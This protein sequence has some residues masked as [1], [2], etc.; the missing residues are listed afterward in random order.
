MKTFSNKSF[1]VLLL[2]T[3]LF[4]T[5]TGCIK[6]DDN[7]NNN[8]TETSTVT[9][10]DG[11]VYQTVKIGFQWWMA[12]NL[13]TTKYNDGSNIIYP[14]QDT[15]AWYNNTTGAYAWYN[16]DTSNKDKYGA[17]YN[18]FAVNTG[19]LCP[20]G[21]SVPTHSN[22]FNLTM[23]ADTIGEGTVAGKLKS[24]RQENSPQ[25]GDC[26]TNEHP[27]WDENDL[28]YGTDLFG[29]KALPGGVRGYE[30][31]YGNIGYRGQWWTSSTQDA[32][33]P[34]SRYMEADSPSVTT[35]S[36]FKQVGLSV[37]CIKNED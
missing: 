14:G 16:D 29:F 28:H 31:T 32:G 37:R 6:K 34:Y 11:N 23:H 25:G 27:R 19:K 36:P 10:I 1:L 33:A 18:W 20:A 2:S 4:F 7:N 30:G 15:D 12:E 22:W 9:D 21:W 35:H 24:C 3:T 13:K 5:I 8:G 26:A 17:L